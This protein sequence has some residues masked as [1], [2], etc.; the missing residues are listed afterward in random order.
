MNGI[1]RYPYLILTGKVLSHFLSIYR[2]K[3]ELIVTLANV[4]GQLI[5]MQDRELQAVQKV[6]VGI[7]ITEQANIDKTQVC[8]NVLCN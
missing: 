5:D 3:D 4:K 8:S 2:E 1:L 7:E 6:K